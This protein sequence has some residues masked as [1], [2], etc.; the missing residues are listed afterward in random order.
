MNNSRKLMPQPAITCD[1]ARLLRSSDAAL[2]KYAALALVLLL[3]W[4]SEALAY[5]DPNAGG[6]IAQVL[7]PLGTIVLSLLFYCRQEIRR[8]V[9]SIRGRRKDIE[10]PPDAGAMRK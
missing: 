4:N 1:R 8:F 2:I 7:A 10:A 6:F 3:T 5:I 9:R